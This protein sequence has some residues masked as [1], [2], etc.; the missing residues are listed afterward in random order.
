[1]R[2]AVF[3]ARWHGR[4]AWESSSQERRGRRWFLCGKK[5][6]DVLNKLLYCQWI[7]GGD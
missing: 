6:L 2:Q 1:V 7:K 3:V 5:I 4:Q